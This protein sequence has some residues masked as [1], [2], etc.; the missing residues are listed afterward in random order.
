MILVTGANGFVGTTL[1]QALSARGRLTLAS[2]RQTSSQQRL[3]QLP[4]V[5]LGLA[6][7]LGDAA[8]TSVWSQ[9]LKGCH[10]VVHTAA[11]VHV[12]SPTA[13]DN[14]RFH[15]INVLATLELA[16]RAAQAGARRFVFLS[17]IK[18]H[19]ERTISGCPFASDQRLAPSGAYAIS[20]Q[21]AEEGLQQIALE[22]GLETVII[23]PPLIYGPGV[24][25]NLQML[26]RW[27]R[28][29]I[30][31]PVGA[32][33]QNRRSLVGVDNLID[34]II[35]AIDHP[36]A[37]NRQFLVS[38]DHDLSTADLVAYLGNAG[39]F[40]ARTVAV[41]LPLLRFAAKLVGYSSHVDRL[42]ENLQVDIRATKQILNW[43]P[44]W[45]LTQSMAR[46][47]T[48]TVDRGS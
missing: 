21:Q 48:P 44:P 12:M 27:M 28:R 32:I 40:E 3:G 16:R 7:D 2:V 47:F 42:T 25:G 20:K 4:Y 35:T 13:E 30:T 11:M 22:T 10:T 9:L 45:T 6:P 19:G 14:A 46:I 39:Q 5:T 41:P 8:N 38:D 29:G 24:S 17:T 43:Q 34:L 23:R 18:V 31:L 36:D 1:C 26:I 15:Q 37:A 33:K